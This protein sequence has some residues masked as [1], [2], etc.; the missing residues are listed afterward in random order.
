MRALLMLLLL[1][2]AA[3]APAWGEEIAATVVRAGSTETI[4]AAILK[5]AGAGP[6]PAVVLV[7]DCSGLGPRSSGAPRRWAAELVGH[8]YVTILPDSFGTRGFPAGVCTV[9]AN[10][11]RRSVGPDFRVGDALGALAALKAQPYVDP[12]RIAI[13]GGSH[14]G[15][16]TLATLIH[17]GFAAGI[18]LYPAC[19]F[20]YGDWRPRIA[21]R[22]VTAFEGVYR[23]QAP[24][25][26]LAGA[27][28]D[29]TPAAHCEAMAAASRAAGLPVELHVYPGAHHSFDS[30]AP[31]RFVTERNNF[32]APEGH[33]ATTGGN[34]EAWAAARREVAAF[35]ARTM[36]AR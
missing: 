27:L 15:S 28:D 33:G 35:L 30:G 25:L 2:G 23:P 1:A 10:G 7:H 18:A 32:W 9:A 11:D 34:A 4:P 21:Q 19:G 14:G 36:P 13:M 3:V 6:F 22:Q 5:P 12:R 17:A 26:I 29:W 8:G 24:L 20:R 31:V 16:T